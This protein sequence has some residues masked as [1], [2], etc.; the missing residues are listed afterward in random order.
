M[1]TWKDQVF[2]D[3]WPL[4]TALTLVR[5]PI[6]RVFQAYREEIRRLKEYSR[7]TSRTLEWIRRPSLDAL[8]R[9]V[10]AFTNPQ[11][12]T[13][14]LPTHVGWTVLWDN[15]CHLD[16][17][18]SFAHCLTHFRRLETLNFRS[19]DG[20]AAMLPGT[21]FTHRLPT[22]DGQMTERSVYCCASDTGGHWSFQQQGEPLPVEDLE[23]YQAK[24]KRNRLNEELLMKMLERLGIEPWRESTY[25]FESMCFCETRESPILERVTF[26]QIRARMSGEPPLAPEKEIVGPPD[27]LRDRYRLQQPGSPRWLLADGKW[28]GHGEETFW[29]YD[30]GSGNDEVFSVRLPTG[31]GPPVVEVSPTSG[32]PSFAIYDTRRHPASPFVDSK[33]EPTF[34]PVERCSKCGQS[35]FRVA[36]GFEVPG[37]ATSANDTSW[38]ALALKCDNCG[39]SR[40]AFED[41]TA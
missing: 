30:I 22:P 33:S 17:N 20:T 2:E 41:E 10:E 12:I 4:P 5:A 8:F 13:F 29:I 39:D 15:S 25:D 38:F 37:D 34:R 21:M 27:Y 40:I 11:T 19:N 35:A 3:W 9:G 14:G 32:G 16:G 1:A 7:D 36:V 28:C 18:N 24:L 31:S 23:Q 6:P 26:A